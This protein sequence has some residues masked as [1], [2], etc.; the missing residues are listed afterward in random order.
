M[1]DGGC[2][3]GGLWQQD[4]DGLWF[5]VAGRSV[6][7]YMW[8]NG[9]SSAWHAVQQGNTNSEQVAAYDD[10]DDDD[11]EVVTYNHGSG[12][13]E[14]LLDILARLRG[15]APPRRPSGSGRQ[16]SLRRAPSTAAVVNN[17]PQAVVSR[18]STGDPEATHAPSVAG[19][20]RS[21]DDFANMFDVWVPEEEV[22]PARLS[23]AVAAALPDATSAARSTVGIVAPSVLA[24]RRAAA[25][26][27]DENCFSISRLVDRPPPPPPPRGA[28][29]TRGPSVAVCINNAESLI[30]RFA[31]R[32]VEH[33]VAPLQRATGSHAQ[34]QQSAATT[35][36]HRTIL[37]IGQPPASRQESDGNNGVCDG[38][39]SESSRNAFSR[40]LDRDGTIRRGGAPLH[41]NNAQRMDD[42]LDK[43]APAPNPQGIVGQYHRL[44]RGGMPPTT[45]GGQSHPMADEALDRVERL[46]E[47]WELGG[48]RPSFKV[49][50]ESLRNRLGVVV[51][52][53]IVTW[54]ADI[55]SQMYH[56]SAARCLK[57][58]SP[59]AL[60]L[61][62]SIQS[63][64]KVL[65]DVEIDVGPPLAVLPS[66]GALPP[67]VWPGACLRVR[68]DAAAV[69]AGGGGGFRYAGLVLKPGNQPSASAIVAARD[70]SSTTQTS[71]HIGRSSSQSRAAP[72]R[73]P[74]PSGL[75]DGLPIGPGDEWTVALAD[76][77]GLLSLRAAS[78]APDS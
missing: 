50:V 49:R 65:A 10:D 27:D 37:D 68:D 51:V 22:S 75:Q 43:V 35:T 15:T 2:G 21:A 48:S 1:I 30:D 57:V 31:Q 14:T 3:D 69:S 26:R 58:G 34:Q 72:D 60:M 36:G 77:E 7:S 41:N 42:L 9:T 54:I 32:P 29:T 74:W 33:A 23:T 44:S 5:S 11:D 53:A 66:I 62:L 46:F 6:F 28:N 40:L 17:D 76:I 25:L 64:T 18:S 78:S 61:S 52:R 13:S 71:Q 59:I 38:Y 4:D 70:P 12:P 19:P 67:I 45:A 47:Q 55:D 63:S 56:A 8:G 16:P 24:A 20:R 73:A 39:V